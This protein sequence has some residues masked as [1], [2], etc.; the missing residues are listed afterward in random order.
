MRNLKQSFPINAT[1]FCPLN[2][3]VKVA[4]AGLEAKNALNYK[5]EQRDECC[6]YF[7]RWLLLLIYSLVVEIGNAA[8]EESW[9]MLL[10]AFEQITININIRF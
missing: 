7:N 9:S 8:R 4:E 2:K 3:P 6:E 5:T 1:P 10:T